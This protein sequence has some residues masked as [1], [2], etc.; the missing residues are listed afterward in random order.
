MTRRRTF[1]EVMVYVIVILLAII[2]L[3]PIYWMFLTSLKTK[4]EVYSA[5]NFV[6]TKFYF[7]NYTE[8]FFNGEM[9]GY[10]LNSVLI[11]SFN[12]LLVLALAIPA[13]YAFSRFKV[14]G[15][16]HIFFWMITNR[17]A[18]PA[19]FLLPMFLIFSALHLLDTHIALVLVYCGFNLP[20]AVWLL[21]GMIDNIPRELD[22]AA[23]IDG[24][25]MW[26]V[27]GRVI[28]PLSKPGIAVTGLL[29]WLFS[30]NHYLFAFMLTN[31]NARTITTGLAEY[32]TVM[33][34]NWGQMA[35]VSMVTMFP[36]F[37]LV[38]FAQK[39]IVSGLT[40]GAV[41]E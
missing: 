14:Y 19:A 28:I 2:I 23:L 34:I 10:L 15:A 5:P 21:K 7:K 9:G 12:A 13:T 11:S 4:T 8:P 30:W 41:K 33:G 38:S 32:V 16:K 39:Y 35:A 22:D 24:C 36:A 18:P 40:F 27:L 20:F 29:T 1:K 25:S 17:M 37:I 6:P 31:T 3:F 26:G